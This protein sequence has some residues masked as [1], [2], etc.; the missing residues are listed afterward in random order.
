MALRILGQKVRPARFL[1]AFLASSVLL[2]MVFI[3]FSPS[4]LQEDQTNSAGLVRIGEYKFSFPDELAEDG[5]Y[6]RK[7]RAISVDIR[8][9]VYVADSSLNQVLVF[10]KGGD[11][12]RRIGN[13]GQGPGEFLAPEQICFDEANS[14]YVYEFGNGRIQVFDARGGYT[15][16]FKV[17]KYI[18]ALRV[19]RNRI[20]CACRQI[21]PGNPLIE[22]L[23]F[24]GRRVGGFGNDPNLSGLTASSLKSLDYKKMDISDS[25]RIWFAWEYFSWLNTFSL[26]GGN[27]GTINISAMR[28]TKWSRQNLKAFQSVKSSKG[29]LFRSIIYAIRAKG[30]CLYLLSSCEEGA[31]IIRCSSDGRI[32]LLCELK[33]ASKKVPYYKDFDLVIGDGKLRFF[34][35]QVY[36]EYRIDVYSL[37]EP[38]SSQNE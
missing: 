36:P 32:N 22:I 19:R 37:D 25:D 18:Q 11:L 2:G 28:Q 20:Y 34:L 5:V 35:L 9:D 7:P 14:L 29:A 10:S 30:D 4:W 3:S 8:G 13:S 16:G 24:E 12:L 17:F 31:E 1:R 6:L 38:E 21:E 33:S 27:L 15:K 26:E 23:D